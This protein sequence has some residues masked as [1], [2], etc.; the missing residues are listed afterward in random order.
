MFKIFSL[1]KNK[2]FS[3]RLVLYLYACAVE[4]L[5]IQ[6]SVYLKSEKWVQPINKWRIS[7]RS[8]GLFTEPYLTCFVTQTGKVRVSFFLSLIIIFFIYLFL[9]QWQIKNQ[10]WKRFLMHGNKKVLTF[11]YLWVLLLLFFAVLSTSL[12]RSLYVFKF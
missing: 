4:I 10:D 12:F 3:G 1:K 9:T 11:Q 6:D 8:V 5:K 7:K 2:K